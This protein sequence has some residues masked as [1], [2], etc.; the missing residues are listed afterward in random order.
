MP[1]TNK[2]IFE[3]LDEISLKFDQKMKIMEN[4]II[5]LE[6]KIGQNIE[7]I[8]EEDDCDEEFF[9]CEEEFEIEE[10]PNHLRFTPPRPHPPAE[11]SHT[12]TLVISDS[13]FRHVK[14]PDYVDVQKVFLPGARAPRLFSELVALSLVSTFSNMVIHFGTNFVNSPLHYDE[15]ADEIS[16]F[17]QWCRVYFP[18][19]HIAFSQVLPRRDPH[20]NSRVFKLNKLIRQSIELM[21]NAEF[22]TYPRI[23]ARRND[24][25]NN[26]LLCKDGLHL[27]RKGVSF[28]EQ[29]L[30][31]YIWYN[32]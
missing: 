13:M 24:G 20:E 14:M 15:I 26:R 3:K 4:Q 28:V 8:V 9:D 27:S 19:T 2:E 17:I 29:R 31:E 5:I 18:T 22:V 1:V 32:Y 7:C 30:E 21:P 12:D 16:D 11:K 6:K 25:I 10:S 23:Q